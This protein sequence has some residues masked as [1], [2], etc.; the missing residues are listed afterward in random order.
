MMR[1]AHKKAALTL[2]P[3]RGTLRAYGDMWTHLF[4]EMVRQAGGEGRLWRL[5][6]DATHTW[7][8]ELIEIRSSAPDFASYRPEIIWNRGGYGDYLPALKAAPNAFRVYYGSGM[9]YIPKDGVFYHLI[10]VDSPDQLRPVQETC[11][12]S[13]VRL[14][15]K[16]AV[17]HLFKPTGAAKDFDL[18]FNC[19]SP[20]E[21][22]GLAW[23]APL[24]P[25]KTKVL[26]IGPPDPL[27]EKAHAERR[28]WVK[29]TGLLP[30]ELVPAWLC[31]AKVGVV[32]DDGR[33]DSGPRILPEMIACGLPVLMRDTVRINTSRYLTPKTGLVVT[34]ETFGHWFGKVLRKYERLGDRPYYERHLGLRPAAAHLLGLV[35]EAVETF[36]WKWDA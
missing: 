11:P 32:C 10:L 17:D 27:F 31:R 24:I 8:P 16:P 12:G 28:F 1:S 20:K 34:A 6:P 25:P 19:H 5:G 33:Y 26:R 22:K 30:I 7:R 14:F 2:E 23:L 21:E 9:R 35:D 13:L 29:F 15:W 18:V 3:P 36:Q 4:A